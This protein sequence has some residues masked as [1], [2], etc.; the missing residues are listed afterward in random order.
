[1]GYTITENG[2]T[3]EEV[4]EVQKSICEYYGIQMID[5]THNSI[6]NRVNITSM[7]LDGVHPN[8]ECYKCMAK[9]LLAKITYK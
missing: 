8:E 9:E 5:N 7:L 1:M 4:F 2:K 3:L 6:V